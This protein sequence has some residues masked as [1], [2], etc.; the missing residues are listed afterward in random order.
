MGQSHTELKEEIKRYL[1]SQGPKVEIL[2][3]SSRSGVNRNLKNWP[4]LY[5]TG[6]LYGASDAIS[7]MWIE[8][9]VKPDKPSEG[10]LEKIRRLRAAGDTVVVAY[11]VEDVKKIVEGEE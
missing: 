10:Q 11:N 3:L 7:S 9:K 1:I 8:V 5:A 2:D 6:L 4:D